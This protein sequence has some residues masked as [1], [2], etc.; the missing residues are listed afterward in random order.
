MI[1]SWVNIIINSSQSKLDIEYS[2]WYS[3]LQIAIIEKANS[4]VELF[5]NNPNFNLNFLTY[6][7]SALHVACQQNDI[8]LF[9]KIIEHNP[10]LDL[11]N[12]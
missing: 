11:K 2:N 10:N 5:L 7:G 3:P 8:L 4:I 6:H 1:Y 12:Y 9:N